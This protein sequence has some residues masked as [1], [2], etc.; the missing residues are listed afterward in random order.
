MRARVVRRRGGAAARAARDPHALG[1]HA[2]A[3]P[4]LIGGW[5]AQGVVEERVELCVERARE[6]LARGPRG[7]GEAARGAEE[8][9]RLRRGCAGWVSVACGT[10]GGGAYRARR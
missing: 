6:V 2:R 1:L 10:D 3:P 8:D 5:R 9:V 7:M 4:L